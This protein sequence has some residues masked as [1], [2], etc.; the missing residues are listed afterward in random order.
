MDVDSDQQ[1]LD[2]FHERIHV[3]ADEREDIQ[4]RTFTRWINTHLKK[5]GKAEVEDLFGDFCN[6]KSLLALL[7]VLSGVSLTPERGRMRVHFLNNV[8]KAVTFLTDKCGIRLVN[9]SSDDIVNGNVKLILG[10][11]WTIISHWQMAGAMAS[12]SNGSQE[13]VEK[14][15]L[16]WCRSSTQ[17]YPN[18]NI[19][20]FTSSWSDGFAFNALMHSHRPELFD[21]DELVAVNDVDYTLIHAFQVADSN[22]QIAKLLEPKDMERPD[23][24][25]VLL[26]VTCLYKALYPLH[27][28]VNED[29]P[30]NSFSNPLHSI[31]QTTNQGASQNSLSNHISQSEPVVASEGVPTI[32]IQEPITSHQTTSLTAS[33]SPVRPKTGQSV[34]SSTTPTKWAVLEGQSDITFAPEAQ[35][36]V[37]SV[38]IASCVSSQIDLAT[39]NPR[40]E[41]TLTWLHSIKDSFNSM[42]PIAESVDA[43]KVQFHEHEQYMLQLT[44]YQSN[45]GSL[46]THGNSLLLSGELSTEQDAL[47]RTKLEQLNQEWEELRV[48]A[49]ERQTSLQKSLMDL[50]M[51]QLNDLSSWLSEM[52][53]KIEEFDKK[54]EN[55]DTL[56][57][58]RRCFEE[59]KKL[60]E[61]L[62]KQQE[63]VDSLQNMVVI[64][65]DGVQDQAY[66]SME[67]LL[68]KLAPRWTKICRWIEEKW[69]RLHDIDT[70]WSL[71]HKSAGLFDSWLTNKEVL[72]GRM[73]LSDIADPGI[74]LHQVQH[75]KDIEGE[76]DSQMT[77]YN[78]LN[79]VGHT[80]ISYLPS[81]PQTTAKI[82]AKLDEYKSRW[83]SLVQQMEQQSELIAEAG[84]HPED[85][86]A[87][88]ERQQQVVV[89][90]YDELKRKITNWLDEIELLSSSEEI[91]DRA[92]EMVNKKCKEVSG[93]DAE[94]ILLED[95]VKRHSKNLGGQRTKSCQELRERWAEV[96]SDLQE[97]SVM[98]NT[99]AQVREVHRGSMNKGDHRLK[100][101]RSIRRQKRVKA[102]EAIDGSI[103]KL[104]SD[105]MTISSQLEERAALIGQKLVQAPPQKYLDATG[106]LITWLGEVE[107]VLAENVYI[108]DISTMEKNVQLY[109]NLQAA[110][111][112][113]VT[114]V[115]YINRTG[116]DLIKRSSQASSSASDSL[117]SQ[118]SDLNSRWEA[119]PS[120]IRGKLAQLSQAIEK[121][122][123]FEH[124]TLPFQSQ[125]NG[126]TRWMSDMEHFLEMEQPVV[127]DKDI[128]QAQINQSDG[129]LTDIEMLKA[130]VEDINSNGKVLVAGSEEEFG[131]E[132]QKELDKMNERWAD[133]CKMSNAQN[134]LLKDALGWCLQIFTTAVH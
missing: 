28:L 26:Y 7:E 113:H 86:I 68:D 46:L 49:M 124:Y 72:L 38:T 81:F 133:I 16:A 110:I 55:F 20:N 36:D 48:A 29:T 105:W 17:G 57:N 6:G 99:G 18:V 119:I 8:T 114:D 21:Y 118:L 97:M 2:A 56:D 123:L 3:T 85:I 43:V 120:D 33:S 27:R 131:S 75:L 34:E 121:L 128:L 80:L 59:H 32:N 98:M 134:T 13:S 127:G 24:K 129:A 5:N 112:E 89:N 70:N 47:L 126:L 66:V 42:M 79:K 74:L 117:Q 82:E 19:Q 61:S 125:V 1:T 51:A 14:M 90:K 73:H 15:L 37:T 54:V 22:F 103:S 41:S 23:K 93:K 60:Q 11:V 95:F 109:Q 107:A 64:V 100:R 44:E 25:S 104:S 45:I 12:Q 116:E 106:A 76:L 94:L 122:R 31:N 108:N 115:E 4:K 58:V 92:D 88:A 52:E 50:Q 53:Q 9:I 40:L 132:L 77:Q 69:T 130:V 67:R 78:Q 91:I 65:E 83:D 10:L 96:T 84:I 35:S 39:I 111:A 101:L 71:F 62:E 63:R 102:D 87:A 30:N